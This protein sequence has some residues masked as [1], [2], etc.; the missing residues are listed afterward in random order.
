MKGAP[1][2]H[3]GLHRT[4][5]VLAVG[6]FVALCALPGSA[7]AC[8]DLPNI[9]EMNAQHHQ[10]MID[11]AATQQQQ[12]DDSPGDY[13]SGPAPRYDPV[14]GA[15]STMLSIGAMARSIGDEFEEKKKDPKFAAALDRYHNGGWDYFQDV[16]KPKAGEYCA[17]LYAKGDAM[18]RVSGPG[19]DYPGALLTFSGSDIPAPRKV[20]K[21][22]VT[23]NQSD[24]SSQTV[25]AFNYKLP[26]E[27]FASIAFAVPTIEAALAEMKDKQGFEL[28]VKGKPV[29]KLDWHDGLYARAQLEK[30]LRGR[31][32]S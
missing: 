32:A 4:G 22:K 21:I 11:I 30:C 5:S 29:A 10:N 2:Q 8:S 31:K 17:A 19:S 12:G 15:M 23:L 16:A 13:D 26:N 24:G 20:R 14:A 1:S 25:E 7:Q 18:V 3:L 6:L 9:C 28:L 27:T